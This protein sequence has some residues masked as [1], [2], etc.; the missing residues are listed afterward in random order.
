M[1][2]KTGFEP[3]ISSLARRRFTT[4]PLP[5]NSAN[6]GRPRIIA[7]Q[8]CRGTDSNCRHRHFQC[9]ALPPEL[10]RRGNPLSNRRPTLSSRG[11]GNWQLSIINYQFG[12]RMA[13]RRPRRYRHYPPPPRHSVS[14]VIPPPPRHSCHPHRH[15]RC[16]H[17]HSR[18]PHRHSG[19]GRNP[20]PR[21]IP[22]LPK[23]GGMDSRFRGNDGLGM[24]G[25]DGLG[26]SPPP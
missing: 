21:C 9:R 6:A 3:A 4:K 17:R 14:T 13:A 22:A 23:A 5:L 7:M 25:N 24:S 8:W 1:E 26:S 12:R 19:V 11:K 16:P 10:P 18:C 2:R 20:E 15:S